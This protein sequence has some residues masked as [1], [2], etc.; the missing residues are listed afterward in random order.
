VVTR[1]QFARLPIQGVMA[2]RDGSGD[3]QLTRAADSRKVSGKLPDFLQPGGSF[4]HV[5]SGGGWKTSLTLVN[6]SD[7]NVTAHVRFFDDGGMPL[8]LSLTAAHS[9]PLNSAA[10]INVAMQPKAVS[11]IETEKP[12]EAVSGWADVYASGP[13]T[14]YAIFRQPLPGGHEAEG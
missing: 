11:V 5:V 8:S 4:A 9:A 14:G 6:V 3:L 7:T 13:L 2:P 1:E 12:G 10:F